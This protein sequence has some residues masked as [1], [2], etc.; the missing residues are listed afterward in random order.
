M[1]IVTG[2]DS[3]FEIVNLPPALG[4]KGLL[5]PVKPSSKN[6]YKIGLITKKSADAAGYLTYTVDAYRLKERVKKLEIQ[7]DKKVIITMAGGERQDMVREKE[8]TYKEA[9]KNFLYKLKGKVAK[10]PT[11]TEADLDFLK[12]NTGMTREEIK[13]TFDIINLI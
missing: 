13:V 7:P 12:A 9:D 5:V 3:S 10:Q 1:E 2:R 11:L 4:N 8:D 6:E